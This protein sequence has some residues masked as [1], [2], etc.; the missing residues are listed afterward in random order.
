MKDALEGAAVSKETIIC[1]V[2][3]GRTSAYM[4]WWLKTHMSWLYDFKFI[5][6]NTGQEHPKTLDF[7]NKV[8]KHFNLDLIWVEAV[9]HHGKRKS[10]SHKVVSY[11]IA[12]REGRVFEEVIKKYG[13]P[14]IGYMHCTRELKINAMNSWKKANGYKGCRTALGIRYD[15]FTR[16]TNQKDII[17]PLATIAKVTK[18]DVID[19]WKKQPFDLEIKEEEGNCVFCYKKSDIKLSLLAASSPKIFNWISEMEDQY[20]KPGQFI[21]R[22][23]RTVRDVMF[24]LNLPEDKTTVDECPEEC[25]TVIPKQRKANE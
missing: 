10:S 19:F 17:Y 20:G 13:L 14:R 3:G 24:N 25:G 11:E 7:V 8:D 9:V 2:S 18:Q 12:D 6:A 16:V 15:E 22:H 21:Y 1:T 5:F 4:A 23:N